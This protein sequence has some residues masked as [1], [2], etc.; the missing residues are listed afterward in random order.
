MPAFWK[1]YIPGLKFVQAD[2]RNLPFDDRAFDFVHSS[3]V[4]EHVGGCQ[5]QVA[6]LSEL[7][8]VARKGIFVTTPNRWFPIEFHT[9]L[10]LIHWLPARLY[11]QLLRML[12]Q[13]FFAE[14]ANLNLTSR[15]ELARMASLAG[16]D[17]FRVETVTLCGWPTNLLLVAEKPRQHT[18]A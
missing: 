14:E 8:R 3:A 15:R 16:I 4:F 1:P 10:P 9:V 5:Q 12:N 7:W 6:F 17:C 13:D 2:G 18:V 11:R